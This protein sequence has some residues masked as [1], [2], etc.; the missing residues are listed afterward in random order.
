MKSVPLSNGLGRHWATQGRGGFQAE[1]TVANIGLLNKKS[2][3]PIVSLEAKCGVNPVKME[4][5]GIL[6]GLGIEE[7]NGELLWAR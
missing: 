6:Q 4:R 3:T 1:R 5:Y 7:E 2:R